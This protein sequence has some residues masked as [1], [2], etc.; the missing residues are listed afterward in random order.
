MCAEQYFTERG[1]N[2]E[3]L[4]ASDLKAHSWRYGNPGPKS[5]PGLQSSLPES[6]QLSFQCQVPAMAAGR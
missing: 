4:A 6:E 3:S 2:P 1:T 5:T